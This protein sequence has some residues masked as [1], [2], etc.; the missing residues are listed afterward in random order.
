MDKAWRRR[1]LFLFIFLHTF[2]AKQ[3]MVRH[4]PKAMR[5]NTNSPAPG[6]ARIQGPLQWGFFIYIYCFGS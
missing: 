4:R 6:G 1:A 3:V 5:Q 2:F